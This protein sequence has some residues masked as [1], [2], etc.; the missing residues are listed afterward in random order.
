MNEIVSGGTPALSEASANPAIPKI[1][2]G[3][4]FPS[5][6]V[7]YSLYLTSFLQILNFAQDSDVRSGAFN[8]QYDGEIG[9]FD[10][11]PKGKLLIRHRFCQWASRAGKFPGG[12]FR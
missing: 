9:F 6:F 7:L 8:Q 12:V 5:G 3:F 4:V 11:Q 2:G 10:F 1:L